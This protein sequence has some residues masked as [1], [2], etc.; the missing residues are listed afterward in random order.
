MARSLLFPIGFLY[1]SAAVASDKPDSALT[2]DHPADPHPARVGY[3]V[4]AGCLRLQK[5]L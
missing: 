1:S 5:G 2:Q 3:S 4:A